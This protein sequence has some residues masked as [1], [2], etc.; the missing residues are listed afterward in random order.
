[1]IATFASA[2]RRILRRPVRSILTVLEVALGAL[3]VTLALNLVQGRSLA[4]LPPDIFRV[5]AGSRSQSSSSSYGLF[6]TGDIGKLQPLIPDAQAV[7]IYQ[8]IWESRLEYNGERFKLIGNARVN[9]GF[10]NI[11]PLEMVQGAFF[12]QKDVTSGTLPIVIAQSIAKQLFGQEAQAVGKTV[13]ISSGFSPAGLLG[14]P[15][16]PY[17]IR[18]VFRDPRVSGFGSADYVYMAFKTSGSSESEGELALI[19]KSKP[20]KLEVAKTQALQAIRSFYKNSQVFKDNKGAIYATTSKNMFED[21]PGLDPQALLFA[22]FAIIMLITCSI[23]IFS[24]QLVDIT[25]RTKEIGMRRAL[26]ATR[27]MIVLESL[28]SSCV[29]A[30][31]GAVIG[32]VIAAPLLPIIKNATGPFLFARGLEFSPIVALEVVGIVLLVGVMLGIYPALL[33]SKLKPVE[34]LREM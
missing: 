30:G 20:G 12:S 17:R 10:I 7:E 21:Q 8:N 1:M 4:A 16:I 28:A 13:L 22:G 19:I 2:L 6:K 23:G 24:I 3:A 14:P 29:L 32:V 27:S 11:T 31:F 25:E 33:A 18:G 26:G 15:Y 34:A 9:P 5:I